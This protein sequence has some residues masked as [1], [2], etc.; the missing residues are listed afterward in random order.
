MRTTAR[1]ERKHDMDFISAVVSEMDWEPDLHAQARALEDGALATDTDP[2][3]G[4]LQ[5]HTSGVKLEQ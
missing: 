3:D 5:E 2:A 1:A 4:L